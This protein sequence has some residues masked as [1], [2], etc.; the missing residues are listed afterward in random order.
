MIAI[1]V[2]AHTK[3]AAQAKALQRDVR[4]DVISFDSGLIG[5]A[6]NHQMLREHLAALPSQ[7][8]VVLED[9]AA[10]IAGFRA[11]LEAALQAAPTPIVSFYL[12]RM[13]P[14]SWMPTVE[15][16]LARANQAAAHWITSSRLLHAVAY[17][18]RTDL[19]DSLQAHS[20]DLSADRHISHWA[21][22]HGHLISYTVG[23]LVEHR[24]GPTL[25]VHPD[26]ED[27]PPGRTAWQLGGHDT[28]T[29][30]AV[31]MT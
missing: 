13:R 15:D 6:G 3:R 18:I 29:S 30:T 17:A 5:C 27:R 1:G 4:A 28:W 7:F 22:H 16:A 20:S 24:D 21:Q 2:V 23:S 19:L 8:S 31:A 10:P 25:F 9:D 14:A 12:G 26:G 11:Q